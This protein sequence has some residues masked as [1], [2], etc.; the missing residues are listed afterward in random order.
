MKK[1]LF[2]TL[3][4]IVAVPAMAKDV[5]L[6]WDASPTLEVTGYMLYYGTD[7]TNLEYQQ[8]AGDA[9][10]MKIDDIPAGTWYFAVTAYSTDAESGY[11]NMV[12]ATI[13]GFAPSNTAH[14][15]IVVPI[16]PLN[17]L[18]ITIKVD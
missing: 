13:D 15:P 16:S 7:S 11:S 10:T 12:D 5:T 1:L 18:T 2:L 8:D 14:A 3:L 6:S 4:L 17:T 9:L